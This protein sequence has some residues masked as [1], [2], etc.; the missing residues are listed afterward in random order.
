MVVGVLRLSLFFGASLSLKEKRQGVR[1]I[2][3]RVRHKF[4]VAIAEVGGLDTWQRATLGVAVVS[5]ESAHAQAMIDKI[6]AFVEGLYVGEVLDR[7]Q[8]LIHYDEDE[9]LDPGVMAP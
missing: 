2:C 4:N 3:D 9:A 8:E 7:E 1:R 5:N 6:A